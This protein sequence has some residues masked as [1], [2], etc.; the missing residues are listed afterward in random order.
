MR[1]WKHED[2]EGRVCAIEVPSAAG[3]GRVTRVVGDLAGVTILRRPRSFSWLREDPFCEFELEGETFEIHEPFG[4]N[5]R[6]W[7]GKPTFG[8]TSAFD[9]VVRAFEQA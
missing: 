9:R 2:R 6:Y 5:S 4:D 3:R 1:V 7:V 8:W